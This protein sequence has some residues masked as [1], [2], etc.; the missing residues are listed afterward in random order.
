MRIAVTG[1]NGYLGSRLATRLTALGHSVIP[2]VRLE[3]HLGPNVITF[4]LAVPISSELLKRSGAEALI[5]CAYDF[6][7]RGITGNAEINVKGAINLFSAAAEA[8]IPR[9]I[10]ISSMSAY[11]GC[12]SLYGRTKLEIEGITSS[13]GGISV[14]PG[15]ICGDPSGGMMRILETLVRLLPI[16]PV[17]T[18]CS[19]PLRLIEET[20]LSDFLERLCCCSSFPEPRVVTCAVPE[21]L[22]IRQILG[23][24]SDRRALH[25]AFVPLPWQPAWVALAVAYR[26][27]VTRRP[28]HDSLIGLVFADPSPAI[29]TPFITGLLGRELSAFS[30]L[31]GMP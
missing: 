12:K 30:T 22:D 9:L 4:D 1:A 13:F 5:H 29:D 2:L 26:L 18:P 24:L 16:V 17:P 11:R 19:S 21:P 14:R 7:A 20:D 31:R 23:T 25:R 10:H 15:L 28:M 8:G 27:R 6:S 3:S